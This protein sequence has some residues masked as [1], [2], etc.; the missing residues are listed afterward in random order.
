ME[1]KFYQDEFEQFLQDEV[2]QHRMYPSDNIWKNI[3]MELHGYKAWPALTFI[4]LFIITALTIS[5][6]L[7]N[8]P[9]KHLQH[10]NINSLTAN[11]TIASPQDNAATVATVEEKHD[12]FQQIV[13]EQITA[14]TFAAFNETDREEPFVSTAVRDYSAAPVRTE[15][16]V[17]RINDADKFITKE[18]PE[19]PQQEIQ[20]T[21]VATSALEKEENILY[22]PNA[23]SIDATK[24]ATS[25]KSDMHT[26]AD[27]YLKDFSPV[28][29]VTPAKRKSSKFGFEFYITPSTS[30]RKLSDEKVKEIIQ[31]A[32]AA[33]SVQN[34]PLSPNYSVDINDVVRHKPAMGLEV[35]FA[36]LYN[37]SDRLKFK[38]GAQLNIRQYY[39]ETYQSVSYDLGSLSLINNR[40]IET[41]SFYTPYNNN[42]GYK[43]T[44]LDN[45]L[46]QLSIPL[47]IQWDLIRGKHFGIST[48]ASVQPTMTLNNSTFLLA[49]DYKHYAD[50]N[51]FIRKWNINT[52]VGLNISY[53]TGAGTWQLGPQIRYQHL[54]TYSN[55][56]PIK[57]YLLDYGVRIGFTKQI[58]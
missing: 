49:T 58:K 16:A 9:D 19:A 50:G 4:S 55:A 7:I 46:Y 3:R 1:N 13:P 38:T 28:V 40:G 12:Y 39:I 48:E 41:I 27:E 42:T 36:V 22:V 2:K 44:E 23:E 11:N 35:G 34:A 54:P 56:Y 8:H 25:I 37:I 15:L 33:Q 51:D 45:K 53:K 18:L 5:T 57:E 26:T 20:N 6:L 29:N 17:N 24:E 52:S 10:I 21:F 31:P 30:Y 43:Q 14:E 47:G 32:V